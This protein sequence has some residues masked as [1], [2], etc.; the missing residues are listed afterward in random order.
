MK[1]THRHECC[2]GRS[3]GPATHVGASVAVWAAIETGSTQG[4]LAAHAVTTVHYLIRRD[5]GTARAKR[6]ISTMLKVFGVATV[7]GAVIELAL[8]LPSIRF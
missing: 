1:G 4:L 5:L 6:T 2:L 8:G 7:D 3:A